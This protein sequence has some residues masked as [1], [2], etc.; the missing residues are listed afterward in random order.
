MNPILK[1]CRVRGTPEDCYLQDLKLRRDY[2]LRPLH[3]QILWHCD[4]LHSIEE[5]SRISKLNVED[6]RRILNITAKKELLDLNGSFKARFASLTKS[7]YL[8]EVQIDAIGRCNLFG[9]CKHCYGRS[10]FEQAAK[11]ELSTTEMF[12]LFDQ[13][14]FLTNCL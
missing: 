4:G 3:G 9:I 12:L 8:R 6:I 7:P 11:G 13:I 14:R 5:L 1:N 2:A 10:A